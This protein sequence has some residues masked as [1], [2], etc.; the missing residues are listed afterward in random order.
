MIEF[1]SNEIGQ[2]DSHDPKHSEQRISAL[3]KIIID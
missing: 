3:P 2:S 1:D